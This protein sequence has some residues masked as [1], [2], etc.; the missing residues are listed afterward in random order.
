DQLNRFQMM[1]G[2]TNRFLSLEETVSLLNQE[3]NNTTL[4]ASLM[5]MKPTVFADDKMLP[6]VPQSVLNV[7]Q[8][9]RTPTR[10]LTTSPETV[11]A[12][13]AAPFDQVVNG[14]YSLRIVV[15]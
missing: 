12:Q 2:L 14:S 11:V 8:L 4:Y 7:M 3:R 15:R 10:G 1:A 6:S 5:Q 13:A 9:G